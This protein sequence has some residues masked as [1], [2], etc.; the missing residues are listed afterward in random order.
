VLMFSDVMEVWAPFSLS[1][2]QLKR[3]VMNHF[4]TLNISI[5]LSFLIASSALCCSDE[6]KQELS[7]EQVEK[8]APKKPS[9]KTMKKAAHRTAHEKFNP[10]REA[11][12]SAYV[13]NS[14]LKQA[15]YEK[16]AIDEDV[17]IAISAFRPSLNLMGTATADASDEKGRQKQFLRQ[18]PDNPDDPNGQNIKSKIRRRERSLDTIA[19]LQATQNL[20]HGG[21][22]LANLWA[23][24]SN[25][26]ANQYKLIN[27]EQTTL[28]K[29]ATAYMDVI[30]QT[31]TLE[32]RN[33]NVIFLTEQLRGVRAQ[34]SVGEK[35]STD[36]ALSESALAQAQAEVENTVRDL[37]D[38]KANYL[39]VIGEKPG[40]LEFPSSLPDLPKTL[41]EMTCD[42]L[43]YNPTILNALY[44]AR[45]QGYIIDVKTAALLP[46]LD[47]TAQA[48]RDL[49]NLNSKTRSIP[50][51]PPRANDRNSINNIQSRTQRND[52]NVQ[53][54]LTIP[55]Y[56]NGGADYARVRQQVD[57]AT[58]ARYGLEQARKDTQENAVKA[59]Y[60]WTS[61]MANVDSYAKQVEAATLARDGALLEADVG[62]RSYLE[63]I[64]LQQKLI[65]A[66]VNLQKALHDKI[67]AEFG[68]YAVMGKLS[69]WQLKLPVTLYDVQG[70]YDSVRCKWI[71]FEDN[72]KIL[73]TPDE[74]DNPCETPVS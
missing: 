20:Y 55:I 37:E 57:S 32:A 3:L 24:E 59:W 23:A 38:A 12:A 53:L 35:T 42:A 48:S 67:V 70:H 27:T 74:P 8:R 21:G 64:E 16:F 13:T 5:A 25:V 11:L 71:G 62:E 73:D 7:Q 44:T 33:K 52:A 6:P 39:Q 9:K 51:G 17:N 69:A 46:S 40:L 2:E 22:D 34:V 56:G 41:E 63:L 66:E 4:N 36:A 60:A 30:L 14:T 26:A 54:K 68:I 45:Q 15:L 10:M 29:A 31:A 18:L 72:P 1:T 43:K 65:D 47:L 50:V 61:A 19:T 49:K 28:Q 58:A